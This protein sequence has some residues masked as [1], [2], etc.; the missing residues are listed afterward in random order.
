MHDH[1]LDIKFSKRQGKLEAGRTPGDKRKQ[2]AGGN[3][4]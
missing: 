1:N 3:G 4:S 2:A